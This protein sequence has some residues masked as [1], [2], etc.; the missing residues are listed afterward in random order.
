MDKQKCI[1]AITDKFAF[2]AAWKCQ[3]YG[4]FI[5]G[6]ANLSANHIQS[7]PTARFLYKLVQ[8][9][10]WLPSQTYVLYGMM[11]PRQ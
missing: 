5:S 7:Q 8:T 10:C 6:H 4:F 2:A 9:F 3:V 1:C 11:V